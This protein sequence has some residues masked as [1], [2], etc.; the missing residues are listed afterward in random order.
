MHYYSI[1][2]LQVDGSL[3]S[4]AIGSVE[5]KN[6]SLAAVSV[7]PLVSGISLVVGGMKWLGFSRQEELW[8]LSFSPTTFQFSSTHH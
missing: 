8:K 4:T 7:T 5:Q 2:Y 6:Y 1:Q 3:S